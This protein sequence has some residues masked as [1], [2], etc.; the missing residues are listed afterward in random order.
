MVSMTLATL[1]MKNSPTQAYLLSPYEIHDHEA[2]ILLTEDAAHDA[3]AF[4]SG[5]LWDPTGKSG[6][7]LTLACSGPHQLMDQKV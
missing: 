2:A 1:K 4:N 3:L 7:G 5:Q 6:T